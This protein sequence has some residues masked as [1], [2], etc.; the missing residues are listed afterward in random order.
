MITSLSA[1][2]RETVITTADDDST[3]SVW[4]AQKRYITKLRADRDFTEVESGF[5]GTTEWAVFTIESARWSPVGVKRTRKMSEEAKAVAAERLSQ[6]RHLITRA[7]G[8]DAWSGDPGYAGAHYRVRT[9]RGPARDHLCVGCGEPS[10]HWSYNHSDPNELLGHANGETPYSAHPDF[11]DPRCGSCHVAFDREKAKERR[12]A[13]KRTRKMSES[14]KHRA[15]ERL[16]A[17]REAMISRNSTK[18]ES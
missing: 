14:A 2:E 6:N 10:L 7:S 18:G 16:A 1:P 9:A 8:E 5:Y 11:Y 12:S 4:T 17:Q 13:Q 15:V 3:V